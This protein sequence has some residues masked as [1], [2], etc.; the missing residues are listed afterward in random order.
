MSKNHFQVVI[1]SQLKAGQD[2]NLVTKKLA[3]LFKIDERKAAQCLINPRTIIKDNLDEATANKYLAAIRQTGANCQVVNKTEVEDLPQI[4][5][6]PKAVA[7]ATINRSPN[8]SAKYRRDEPELSLVQRERKTAEETREKLSTMQAASAETI[9]PQCGTLR[10]SVDALC[11]HCGY[12]PLEVQSVKRSFNK[13]IIYVMVIIILLLLASIPFYLQWMA[14]AKFAHDMQLVFDTR[15]AVTSFIERTGFFP[16]QNMD[17]NLPD[18][19]SNDTIQSIIFSDNGT[20]TVT[21]RAAAINATSA[22]TLIFK[23]RRIKDII[24]WNCMEGTL[25]NELR[26]EFC[27]ATTP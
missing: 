22:Q 8:D 4:V 5:D 17:A 18:D 12:S 7:A 23:P 20:M 10:G 21:L 15:K 6:P 25:R 1:T 13:K 2:K 19:I 9:C 16:N 11:M 3:T 27:K 14:K 24:A 26:P